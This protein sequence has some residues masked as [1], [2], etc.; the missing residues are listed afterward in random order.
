MRRYISLFFLAVAFLFTSLSGGWA[1]ERG[2]KDEAKVMAEKAA[3]FFTANGKEKAFAAF[4]NGT[5]GFQDRDL[6]VFV[7][8]NT[9]TCQAIG[10]NKGMAG[11]NLIEM[12]DPTGFPFI[13]AIV[14]VKTAAWVDYKFVNPM[15]KAIENKHAY[16]VRAGDL[17][18]GVG[19]YD[20]Q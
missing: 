17:V 12:K 2:T 6:Y 14:D 13:H 16:V 1:A 10:A 15:T 7:Y 18:F 4:T 19:A 5:D 8:D 20:Q 9:G 3:Q 11:K